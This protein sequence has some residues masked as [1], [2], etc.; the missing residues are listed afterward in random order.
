MAGKNNS[1]HLILE[2]PCALAPFYPNLLF[3]WKPFRMPQKE[4][5]V[6]AAGASFP[7]SIRWQGRAGIPS[8]CTQSRGWA[9]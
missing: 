7:V 8:S 1:P 4:E 6:A 9:Q 2:F 5:G 3:P